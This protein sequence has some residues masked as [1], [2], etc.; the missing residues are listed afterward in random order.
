MIILVLVVLAIVVVVDLVV[1]VLVVRIGPMWLMGIA[2][3]IMASL[4]MARHD[5]GLQ[6]DIRSDCRKLVSE[7]SLQEE[8]KLRGLPCMFVY[9]E[10]YNSYEMEL[11]ESEEIEML[12]LWDAHRA[13]SRNSPKTNDEIDKSY[14]T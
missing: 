5:D 8:M 6:L 10:R 13:G 9:G 3:I 12:T 7:A 1:L 14:F 2:I 11:R 4:W